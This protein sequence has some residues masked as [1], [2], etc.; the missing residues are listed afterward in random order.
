MIHTIYWLLGTQHISKRALSSDQTFFLKE[1]NYK[2]I[3]Q[4][5]FWLCILLLLFLHF[6]IIIEGKKKKTIS[7]WAA[8]SQRKSLIDKP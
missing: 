3:N 5:R 2:K 8:Q 6:H 4:R 7:P 1:T